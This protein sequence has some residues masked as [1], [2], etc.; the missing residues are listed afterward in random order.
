M[1]SSPQA[2][3]LGRLTGWLDAMPHPA[4]V[5]EIAASHVAVARWGRTR[6]SLEGY[7]V[8]PLPPGAVVPS[9]VEP[10]IVMTEPV[11]SAL[12]RVLNRVP[13]PSQE[14]AMLIPDPVVRVFI[15][16]FD[17]LPRRA[18]EALPLL[19]WRLKKSVPF[20][21]EET[22]VSW[23]RQATRDGGLEIVAAVARQ[24]I[25]REY[26]S[27][28]ESAGLSTG[29]VLSSTLAALPLLDSEGA[30]LLARMNGRSLTTVIVRGDNLCVYRSSEMPADPSVL[31]PQAVLDE[32]FPSVAYY[33]DIWGGRMDHACLS[34][35]GGR[36]PL[37]Q[38]AV[39]GELG[40]SVL[41]LAASEGTDIPGEVQALL[42]KD[43]EGLVGW[44][45]NR[46]A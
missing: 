1:S 32:I 17:T 26:E 16:P 40:C 42:S 44:S 43:L 29:V 23:V 10:N 28:L 22:V 2:G 3:K 38:Q 24:R 30:S 34:G 19:R 4:F 33:Q 45:M 25:I 41:S 6:W 5:C 46:G 12:H 18:D 14:V 36:E 35:F 13:G 11:L 21:V 27:L 20:D 31:E 8:E 39:R 15:L 7:A 37:F 9:P